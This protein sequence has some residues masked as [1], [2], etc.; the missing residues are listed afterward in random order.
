MEAARSKRGAILYLG[1]MLLRRLGLVAIALAAVRYGLTLKQAH[2]PHET[3]ATIERAYAGPGVC[4]ARKLELFKIF[5]A[6]RLKG[7]SEDEIRA[8]YARQCDGPETVSGN[9]TV[10]LVW[11]DHAMAEHKSTLIVS[12]ATAEKLVD[13]GRLQRDAVRVRYA[14]TAA[15]AG[16]VLMEE[17]D[18]S[19]A[20]SVLIMLAGAALLVSGVV[21]GMLARWLRSR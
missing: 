4:V 21:G 15:D 20:E 3:V 12:R 19:K 1:A 18:A 16:V 2:M 13:R 11:N 14:S 7:L 9:I 6:Q 10:V 8:E 17:I 5:N